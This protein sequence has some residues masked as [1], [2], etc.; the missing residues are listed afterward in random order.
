MLLLL[1]LFFF[2]LGVGGNKTQDSSP[3]HSL[4][5]QSTCY[6]SLICQAT[7]DMRAPSNAQSCL[8]LLSARPPLGNGDADSLPAGKMRCPAKSQV[9]GKRHAP[10]LG[11]GSVLVNCGEFVRVSSTSQEIIWDWMSPLLYRLISVHVIKFTNPL[12]VS[13]AHFIGQHGKC[14]HETMTLFANHSLRP[15]PQP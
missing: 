14:S 13:F 2:F 11:K 15:T 5:T 7:S 9:H 1:F 4:C 3:N 10:R 6:D 8:F 12:S